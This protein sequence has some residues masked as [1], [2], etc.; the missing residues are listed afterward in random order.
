MSKVVRLI[1]LVGIP[2]LS[3][4]AFHIRNMFCDT[5][6]FLLRCIIIRHGRFSN[7][8][9]PKLDTLKISGYPELDIFITLNYIQNSK[10]YYAAKTLNRKNA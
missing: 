7:K 3:N 9:I 6:H 1:M 10:S 2:T 4:E 5:N 8:I